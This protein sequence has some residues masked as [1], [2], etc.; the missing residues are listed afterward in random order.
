MFTV[1]NQASRQQRALGKMQRKLQKILLL[2]V[3]CVTSQLSAAIETEFSGFANV[4]F[5]YADSEQIEF[6]TSLINVAREGLTWQ[7]DTVVG[8]QM[9]TR[10]DNKLDFVGQVI[11]QDRNDD[12]LSNVLELA[13]LRYQINRNWST[14]LGRF[15][16]NSYLL[17]DYRYVRHAQ[18]WARPPLEMYSPTG[19]LGNMNGL[20]VNYSKDY[21]YGILKLSWSYGNSYFRNDQAEGNLRTKFDDL[22]AF[23]VEMN[24][25]RWRVQANYLS[26][27][28]VD[29]EIAGADDISALQ[30]TLP[31]A[32]IPIALAIQSRI[33]PENSQVDYTTIGSHYQGDNLEF[34]TEIADL[35]SEWA[36]SQSNR[37]A[38]A[39]IAYN[40]DKFTPFI[41]VSGALR[42]EFPEIVDF[43][44]LQ[45]SLPPEMFQQ[46]VLLTSESN[47]LLRGASID[48]RSISMGLR[49]DVSMNWSIKFQVD[50]NRI[51]EAGSG[52]FS[53]VNSE[54]AP[55]ADITYNVV[56][57]SFSTIF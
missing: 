45:A 54:L 39:S 34:I 25:N 3:L 29:F 46:V 49:W 35:K 41:T 16:T 57:L 18:Y 1:F 53:T 55:T 13:F 31:P 37:T 10:L 36:L 28:L 56:N 5:T 21:Q 33:V 11:L 51:S 9:N 4:G 24:T 40:L 23:S 17:T 26:A 19:V 8:L 50:H 48:Q 27:T 38:Y 12:A 15:S 14:K 32:F 20:Q 30:Q 47:E 6:R 43:G 7:S 2:L 52:L 44:E 22:N 42:D